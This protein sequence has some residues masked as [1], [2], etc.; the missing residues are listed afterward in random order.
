MRLGYFIITYTT[1]LITTTAHAESE[2]PGTIAIAGSLSLNGS[3]LKGEPAPA[4]RFW[5]V[6]A[7]PTVDVF[8]GGGLTLGAAAT[9]SHS[10][11]SSPGSDSG[12]SATYLQPG[13]QV[14]YFAPIGE[15]AAFWPVLRGGYGFSW[16]HL[17][18][19]G[20]SFEHSSRSWELSLTPNVLLRPTKTFFVR[21][22]PGVL[23]YRA[24][25]VST[26]SAGGFG[27]LGVSPQFAL[28]VGVML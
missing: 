6:T 18:N 19:E 4:S 7:L 3:S 26:Q 15:H 23:A 21:L 8:V 27:F 24:T 5:S 9:I 11:G 16:S 2:A 22:A 10:R 12:A 25:T 17:E 28:G 14:G 1:L 20:R 13:L